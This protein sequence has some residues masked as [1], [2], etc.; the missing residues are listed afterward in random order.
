[1]IYFFISLYDLFQTYY[2]R[3]LKANPALI[4]LCRRLVICNSCLVA[5]YLKNS[6]PGLLGQAVSSVSFRAQGRRERQKQDVAWPCLLV[7]S[8]L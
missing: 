6:L 2:T 1:M 7:S 4:Q 5:P 8:H 3:S